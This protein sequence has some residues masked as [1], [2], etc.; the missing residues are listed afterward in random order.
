MNAQYR[1]EWHEHAACVGMNPDM[2]FPARGAPASETRQARA[3]CAG[4]PVREQCADYAFEH[5]I[6]HGIFGGLSERQRR[7]MRRNR[8]IA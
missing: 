6:H 5:G 7:T 2:W 4:C 1:P 8:G 3:I